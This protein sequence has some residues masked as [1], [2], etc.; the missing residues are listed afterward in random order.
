MGCQNK[1]KR[2]EGF[3]FFNYYM[4]KLEENSVL[5]SQEKR[6]RGLSKFS[7][8]CGSKNQIVIMTLDVIRIPYTT[9]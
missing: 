6:K 4:I 7:K 2:G 9:F 1:K 3:I 8:S 5:G